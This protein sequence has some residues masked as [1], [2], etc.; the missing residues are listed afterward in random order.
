MILAAL[1]ATAY[2]PM[3]SS[4]RFVPMLKEA[5]LGAVVVVAFTPIT[6]A[7][8]GVK[9]AL[10]AG[11]TAAVVFNL[12]NIP[13][14]LVIGGLVIGGQGGSAGAM[15]SFVAGLGALSNLVGLVFFSPLGYFVGG[16]VGSQ[17]NG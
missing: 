12:V 4:I 5:V 14:Q 13:L 6:T 17:L 3:V 10:A 15:G 1:F 2:V 8:G 7:K 9:Y 16:A 11:M